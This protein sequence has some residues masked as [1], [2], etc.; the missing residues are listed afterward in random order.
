MKYKGELEGFPEEIVEKMLERQ[1]EQGN[2]RDVSVFEKRKSQPKKGFWFDESIEGWCFWHI[3]VNK[4]QFE[5]FFNKY[6]K[7]NNMKK[8]DLKTGMIINTVSKGYCLIFGNAVVAMDTSNG[9][10]PLSDYS[11]D[12]VFDSLNKYCNIV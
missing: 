8:S 2:V 4:K 1:V 6:P 11:K 9:S 10:T 7:K 12:L 3:I 5:V